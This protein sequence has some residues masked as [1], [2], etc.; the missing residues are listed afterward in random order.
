[1]PNRMAKTNREF[2]LISLERRA[3]AIFR[4]RRGRRE[5]IVIDLYR[6][7]AVLAGHTEIVARYPQY[8]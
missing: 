2:V 8:F 7:F 5:E 6:K 4:S 3:I 1:M